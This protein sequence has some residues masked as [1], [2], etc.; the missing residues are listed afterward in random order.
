MPLRLPDIAPTLTD[1]QVL[2]FCRRG[3]LI[4]EGVVAQETN[5]RV[6]EFIRAHPYG[7]DGSGGF[8]DDKLLAEDWFVE[9]GDSQLRRRPVQCARS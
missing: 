5:E 8:E 7:S 1:T 4:L 9:D 6:N 3:Y 2:E